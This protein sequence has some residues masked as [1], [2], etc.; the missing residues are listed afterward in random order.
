MP[1]STAKTDIRILKYFQSAILAVS[2]V[3]FAL[4]FVYAD[5]IHC[6]KA[7]RSTDVTQCSQNVFLCLVKYSPFQKLSQVKVVDL[8]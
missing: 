4:I 8:N 5:K 7:N 6:W 3:S 2:L 1:V